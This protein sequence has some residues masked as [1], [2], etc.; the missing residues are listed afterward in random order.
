MFA[1]RVGLQ[2]FNIEPD[3]LIGHSLGE[4][5][6]LVAAESITFKEG[7]EVVSARGRAMASLA[8]EDNGTMAAVSAPIDKVEEI[9]A[10][11]DTDA[12]VPLIAALSSAGAESGG[13]CAGW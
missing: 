3:M 8:V 9:L 5:A 13:F 12:L 4:Y 7:L 11:I 1:V 2:K 6:A 10:T